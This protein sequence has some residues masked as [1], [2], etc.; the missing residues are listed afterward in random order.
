MAVERNNTINEFS[1]DF[2]AALRRHLRRA[3]AASDDC[4]GFDPELANAYV[5]NALG[6]TARARFDE[7]L[8]ACGVCRRHVVELFRLMPQAERPVAAHVAEAAKP[9][10]LA[11]LARLF[12]LSGWRW[13][14]A[15]L[16]GAC[17]MLLL[18]IAIPLVWQQSHLKQSDSRIAA[19][20]RPVSEPGSAVVM[21]TPLPAEAGA[22]SAVTQPGA[23][24]VAERSQSEDRPE[25]SRTEQPQVPAPSIAPSIVSSA[26][27]ALPSARRDLPAMKQQAGNV[28]SVK[29]SGPGGAGVPGAQ[30]ILKDAA[31]GQTRSTA[32]T[33]SA[34]QS[35]FTNVAQGNYQ[36]VAQAPGFLPQQTG[37]LSLDG[38]R[39][40]NEVALRLEQ[41][42]QAQMARTQ[43]QATEAGLRAEQ[44]QPART[45]GEADQAADKKAGAEAKTEEEK[46]TRRENPRGLNIPK[47]T[48]PPRG[49]LALAETEKSSEAPKAKAVSGQAGIA[50]RPNFGITQT[51]NG[52]T[53]RLEKGVWRDTGYNPNDKWPVIRLTRGSEEY[54]QTIAD[55]PSLR[56]FFT[57]LRGH[58]LVLWQG[59][60]YEVK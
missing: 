10:W 24:A 40:S 36:V 1:D 33:D 12:D 49:S 7:H 3:S 11:G 8:A 22:N 59:T 29:V 55:L 38:S 52:K 28:I 31:T 23:S 32:T 44:E 47:P 26:T 21:A 39:V 34:G 54:D 15:V 45:A 17:A 5:E 6:A 37:N 25:R 14:T 58:V 48:P 42:A 35:N 57:S 20:A 9:S 2:E 46:Q 13:N 4:A 50:Y 41:N 27:P 56:Q 53:F 16:A 18:A 51:V 19:S 43:M 30:V 60:V